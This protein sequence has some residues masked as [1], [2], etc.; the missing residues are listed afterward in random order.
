VTRSSSPT[1]RLS[2]VVAISSCVSVRRIEMMCDFI[3][4]PEVRAAIN[5]AVPVTMPLTLVLS[6]ST[7][8]SGLA[9]ERLDSGLLLTDLPTEPG[10]QNFGAECAVGGVVFDHVSILTFW[11]MN[12]L[13]WR[14]WKISAI[15]FTLTTMLAT[16]TMTTS[17]VGVTFL[18]AVSSSR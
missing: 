14:N 7:S 15:F 8:P 17:Y 12:T 13:A 3:E 4:N 9:S 1:E 2:R 6:V 16:L 18:V 5:R 11:A 10:C